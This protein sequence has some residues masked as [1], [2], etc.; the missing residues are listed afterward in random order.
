MPIRLTLRLDFANGH[1]L[2]PGKVRLL[3]A[4]DEH[5]S[6]SAA[7]RAL[8]MSYRRAWLLL[9]EINRAF[10]QPAVAG[11]TGGS[12]GGGTALTDWGRELV[13]LYRGLEASSSGAGAGALGRI[14]AMLN[15][16]EAHEIPKK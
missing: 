1:R 12:G 15:P 6:I 3:E 2:G 10:T 7:G 13:T 9:D 11:Q 5:G 14:D 16:A 8:G 4:I